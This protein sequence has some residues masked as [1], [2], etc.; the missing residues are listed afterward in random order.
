[1]AI[2]TSYPTAIP[3][4]IDRLIISQAYDIDADDPIVGNPTKSVSI[5]SIIELVNSG[6][7]PGTGTVK[8]VG[9]SMPSAFTVSNS[10]ITTDGTIAITGAGAV[11]QFIDGTGVLQSNRFEFNTTS[12]TGIQSAGNTAS[13]DRSTAMGRGTTASGL[14]STAMGN[15]TT[16]S[17]VAST[18]M[19]NGTTASGDFSTAMGS[20][21]TASGSYS[22]AMGINT[23]ASDYGSLVIGQYNLSGYTVTN[24]ATVFN[25]ANTAFVIGNGAS[26][27]GRADAFK[28]LF[29]GNTTNTG[30]FTASSIIKS[31]GTN[32]Q[33]LMAD[34]SV[35]TG[36][37]GAYLPSAGGDMSGAIGTATGNLQVDPA[38]ANLEVRG[39]GSTDASVTLNCYTN[40]HGQTLKS[41]PHSENITNTMLLPKGA[42]STLVSEATETF[43][44][45]SVSGTSGAAT[46][47]GGVLNI[48]TYASSL[49][50]NTTVTISAAQLASFSGGATIPIVAAQGANKIIIP[51]S[52]ALFLDYNSS[53]FSFGG[54]IN[55]GIGTG[56]NLL[57]ITGS[58]LN[59]AQDEYL[60]ASLGGP[61]LP[62]TAL[63]L[64][65]Q[66][67]STGTG[68]SILKINLSY[69]VIEF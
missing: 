1:M 54:N 11:T 31:G 25:T 18:A 68:N 61:L 35:T 45:L 17:G 33:Y 64:W 34:G 22:T 56:V 23:K 16:A 49:L 3:K 55:L 12:P 42:N 65:S 10:P 4:A 52:V 37:G 7:I 38:T 24:S 6:L 62:N 40:A 41:Q 32:A 48:P 60:M 51:T 53:Q 30:T 63:N 59:S 46:L 47:V 14:Y 28:V 43:Q 21:T 9:V 5:A 58:F 66:G 8:S 57:T 20:L 19:G 29:N 67:V 39:I 2:I 27:A 15:S 69:R 26:A 44:S 36:T 50:L 13:G